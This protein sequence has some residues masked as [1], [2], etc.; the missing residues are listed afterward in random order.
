MSN[1]GTCYGKERERT[2]VVSAIRVD[3]DSFHDKVTFEHKHSENGSKNK[4]GRKEGE[5]ER[6]VNSQSLPDSHPGL[7]PWSVL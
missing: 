7:I 6:K 5:K 4:E 3:K 2:L 1:L